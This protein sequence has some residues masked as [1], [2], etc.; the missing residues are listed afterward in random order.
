M[1][2]KWC[3][4]CKQFVEPKKN[5][6]GVVF[7]LLMIFVWLPLLFIEIMLVGVSTVS[8]SLGFTNITTIGIISFLMF[9]GTLLS[10]VCY[11][12]YHVVGKKAR[13]PICNGTRY[14][15]SKPTGE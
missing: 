2:Q 11:I 15:D 13:C 5:F 4:N 9:I 6:H 10:P 12:I 14:T 7:I 8:Y 1:T 3:L